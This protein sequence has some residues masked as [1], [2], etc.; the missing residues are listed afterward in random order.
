MSDVCA[1]VGLQEGVVEQL[2]Q[3]AE[4]AVEP[5]SSYATGLLAGAMDLQDIASN[6]K[7]QNSVLVSVDPS[8][9]HHSVFQS[10]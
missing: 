1:V 3:W 10:D 4:H 5:L 8:I 9:S 7:E 6:F 2:F